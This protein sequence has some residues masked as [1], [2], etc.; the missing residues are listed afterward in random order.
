MIELPELRQGDYS[1]DENWFVYRVAPDKNENSLI[2]EPIIGIVVLSQSCDIVRDS[3]ERPFLEVCPLVRIEENQLVSEISKGLRPRYAYV[4]A[5]APDML[6]ADLDRI[7]TVDKTVV[8]AWTFQRGCSTVD[9]QVRFAAATA[10]KRS[11][12]AF[13]D[14]IVQL[15]RPLQSRILKKHSKDSPE[16]N[17]L[18]Q[19]QEIRVVAIPSWI[20][21]ESL[22]F[23]FIFPEDVEIAP[24]VEQQCAL[25]TDLVQSP[26]G[27]SFCDHVA[28]H[29]STLSAREYLNSIAL[30]LDHLS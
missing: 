1:F 29:Y 30:D 17:R 20:D 6:V 19:L 18:R 28:T 23:Y 3:A 10:R 24:D 11:R 9:Q 25:W 22:T 15:L 21:P 13:P 16:G 8:S 12:F 14:E 5:A 4:P 27:E 7:M 2:E 26:S